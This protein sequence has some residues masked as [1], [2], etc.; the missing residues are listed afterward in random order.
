MTGL[1]VLSVELKKSQAEIVRDLIR[2]RL[3]LRKAGKSAFAIACEM[4]VIGIDC[5]RRHNVAKH[6][7][8]M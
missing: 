8:K 7:S 5:D 1:R 2:D 6:R 4:N 3:A